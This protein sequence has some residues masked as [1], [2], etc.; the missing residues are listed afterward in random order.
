MNPA[1]RCSPWEPTWKSGLFGYAAKY[2][3]VSLA[4]EN[5]SESVWSEINF[6]LDIS[7]FIF[8]TVGFDAGLEFGH[9]LASNHYT[10]TLLFSGKL[11]NRVSLGPLWQGSQYVV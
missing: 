7:H 9:G 11:N 5:A 2:V 3:S 6:N 4:V 8:C 1:F 10:R